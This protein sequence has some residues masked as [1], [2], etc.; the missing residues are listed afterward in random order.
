M[1][2]K[3][4]KK[5]WKK[6]FEVEKNFKKSVIIL[7]MLVWIA[8]VVSLG[9]MSLVMELFKL[10]LGQYILIASIAIIVYTMYNNRSIISDLKK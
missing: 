6:E 2:N 3:Y 7:A 9:F 5:Q 10:N 1:L 8:Q 4:K